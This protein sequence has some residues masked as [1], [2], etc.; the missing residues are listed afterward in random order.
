VVARL[1]EIAHAHECSAR[2]GAGKLRP[3]QRWAVLSAAGIYGEIATQVERRGAH[4]WDHRTV[5]SDLH[6][7]GWIARAALRAFRKPPRKCREGAELRLWTR[8][9]LAA[10]H[11]IATRPPIAAG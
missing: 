7:A 11:G 3:R 4:A 8:R 10:P 9:D 5:V 6:K 1:V 2:V